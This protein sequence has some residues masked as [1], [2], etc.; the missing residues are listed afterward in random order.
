LFGNDREKREGEI[1]ID[2]I[3]SLNV[4][5]NTALGTTLLQG[6][7]QVGNVIPRVSVESSTQSLLVEVVS[8]ETNA[9]A[10][11][12][13]TV[14]NSH[15]HVVLNFLGRESTAVAHQVDEAD[16]DATI[17]VQNEVVLLG[18][19]D[20]LDSDGI[21][22]ELGAGEVLLD[23]LLDQLDTQ[24]GVVP[25][26]DSVANTRDYAK[27]SICSGDVRY[28]KRSHTQ[29]VLLSH[30]VNKVT[31]A[32]ALVEGLGKL[33]SSTVKSTTEA[34]SDG[35]ETSDQG[36]DQI[37][38][39]TGSDD[40]VH[41]TRH[42]RT[43]VSG[44][45]ENHLQELGGIAR[46]TAT[47]PQKGHDTT[48]ANILSEN[49]GNGHSGVQELL[50]TVVGDGGNEGSGLTDETQLL[51][52]GVVDGDL[53]NLRFGLGLDD[54]LLDLLIVHLLEELGK[55]F[56]RVGNVDTGLSHGLVLVHSGLKLGVGRGTSVTKL[57]LS[58]EH[59]GASTDGPG[60]NR[61]GNGAVLYGFNDTV[62][63]NT[64]DL[65]EQEED[66]AI[67]I[68]LVTQEVVDKSGTGV[69]V[70]TN[71]DTLVD[72]IGGLRDDVVQFVGHTTGLGNV[73]DGTL[74][75]ELR[76]NNIVHH[77]TGVTD[78]E[79]ARLDTTNG[80]RTNDG[81]ALLLGSN[82]DLTSTL[83]PLLASILYAGRWK[84]DVPSRGHPRR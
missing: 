35:Q 67:R 49:V 42:G 78:F 16:S 83:F 4:N 44:E 11:D 69:A 54:A 73:A 18:G 25:G 6:G 57:N 71:G 19:G 17:D 63:L 9:A 14:E 84:Q 82:H 61:L 79:S 20:G 29:L 59:A 48:N 3:E 24:I 27:V 30:G 40:G 56:E 34:R 36:A 62:L 80:S 43:V 53:G 13:E 23:E 45:H 46:Q 8:N 81:D 1:L 15:L 32:H 66:L 47:E 76:S 55:L 65:T 2:I 31:G 12:E 33:L 70:T 26:L 77:T 68:G 51:G 58:L 5:L 52:P 37:L 72:T 7:E 28:P 41:S 64:T 74:T 39:S 75:V 22:E 10:K 50:A 21:V 38:A 60:D